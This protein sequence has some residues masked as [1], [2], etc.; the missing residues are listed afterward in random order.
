MACLHSRALGIRGIGGWQGAC[1]E[2]FEASARQHAQAERAALRAQ[3]E[4]Q[5]AR[6]QQG[7]GA[8]E[9]LK[10]GFVPVQLY[11]F[12]RR[13]QLRASRFMNEASPSCP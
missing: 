1:G 12:N 2:V 3:G 11:T 6:G 8:V 5:A 13:Q 7:H 4:G 9:I 10:F